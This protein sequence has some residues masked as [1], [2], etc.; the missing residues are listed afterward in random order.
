M[1]FDQERKGER[2]NIMLHIDSRDRNIENYPHSNKYVIQLEEEV[3]DVLSA[4]MMYASIPIPSY[5]VHNDNNEFEATFFNQTKRIAIDTGNYTPDQYASELADKLRDAFDTPDASSFD[6]EYNA[7]KDKIVI[8]CDDMFSLNFMTSTLQS[9][10]S[11]AKTSG[12]ANKMYHSTR[13]DLGKFEVKAPFRLNLT[14]IDYALLN[15]TGFHNYTSTN[16]A[17]KKTFAVIPDVSS[18]QTVISESFHIQKNF[19][20]PMAKLSKISIEFKN[21]DGKMYDL[22]NYDHFFVLRLEVYRHSPRY[23]SFI[24]MDKTK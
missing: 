12:F 17:L 18:P 5:T 24:D 13:N 3:E 1:N 8:R 4:E 14:N 9:N 15:I 23:A 7:R 2:R 16:D 10:W 11:F 20:P 22:Q 6:V 19:N 21:R